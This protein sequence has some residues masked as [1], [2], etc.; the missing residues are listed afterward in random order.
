MG[1]E[2]EASELRAFPA[3]GARTL[4]DLSVFNIFYTMVEIFSTTI[5]GGDRTT[6]P[7][8]ARLAAR[9]PR[10]HQANEPILSMERNGQLQNSI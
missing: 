7:A 9:K 5:G 8:R 2:T 10:E 4:S 1:V 3:L 6:T